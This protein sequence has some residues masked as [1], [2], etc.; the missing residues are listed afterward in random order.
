MTLAGLLA[1]LTGLTLRGANP[2]MQR[3]SLA[4]LALGFLLTSGALYVQGRKVK[5]T[6]YQREGWQQQDTL[7]CLACAASVLMVTA[8]HSQH[9]QIL[10]YYPYPPS[11]PWPGFATQVG[12]AAALLAAPAFLWPAEACGSQHLDADRTNPGYEG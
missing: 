3:P 8:A 4:W 12:L 1:L 5:R 11:T 6:H 2:Q 7:V 9:P 10:S